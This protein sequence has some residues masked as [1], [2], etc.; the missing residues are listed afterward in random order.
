MFKQ[1]PIFPPGDVVPRPAPATS[2]AAAPFVLA[3]G[4]PVAFVPI[5]PGS[6]P[7][8]AAAMARLSQESIRR[9]FLA[10]RRELS[11]QELDRLTAMDGW[12]QYAIGACMNGADGKL[13]GIG[14]ARFARL[15]D[16]ATTAEIAIT[17]VD[18][19]HG[20]GIGTALMARLAD[21]AKLRGI[22][23]LMAVVLPDNAAVI[24]L[25]QRFVPQARWRRDDGN[26]VA[27]I[28]LP[29]EPVARSADH[30]PPAKRTAPLRPRGTRR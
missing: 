6:K 27:I 13:E 22:R 20:R 12:N 19:Y 17:V 23:Q 5:T 2:V 25:L 24:G 14:V 26:L 18:A 29:A 28:R 1:E 11:E 30:S 7:V 15:A 10:P 3:D 16:D 4:R 8:I 9:R 21:A